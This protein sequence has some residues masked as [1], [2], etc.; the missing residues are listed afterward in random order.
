MEQQKGKVSPQPA[1]PAMKPQAKPATKAA[2][3]K[4]PGAKKK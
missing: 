1:K 3:I 4:T 2:P